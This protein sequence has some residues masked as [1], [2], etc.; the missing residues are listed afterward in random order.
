MSSKFDRLIQID[1]IR[2]NMLSFQYLKKDV[3]LIFLV[4]LY[5]YRLSG[6]SLNM[7]NQPVHIRSIRIKQKKIILKNTLTTPIFFYDHNKFNL[8]RSIAHGK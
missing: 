7:L 5:F 8:T 2:S 4:K 6:L 1:P 3:I